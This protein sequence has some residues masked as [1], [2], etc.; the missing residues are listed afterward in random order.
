MCNLIWC[1]IDMLVCFTWFVVRFLVND[2][3]F[4]LLCVIS[5]FSMRVCHV[6]RCSTVSACASSSPAVIVAAAKGSCSYSWVYSLLLCQVCSESRDIILSA[7]PWNVL[8]GCRTNNLHKAIIVFQGWI[9][10]TYACV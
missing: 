8:S 10:V 2:Q 3:A 1:Y 5:V 4:L 7:S 9:N 6:F